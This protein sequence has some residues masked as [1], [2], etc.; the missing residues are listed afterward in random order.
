MKTIIL[1]ASAHPE[2]NTAEAVRALAR[3]IDAEVVDLLDYRILPFN[4]RQ[5]YPPEDDFMRLINGML[6]YDHLVFA[7]PVYWY[8]MSGPLKIYFDRISDLLKSHK[9]TGRKL[10]G[11]RMSVLSCANDAE[12]NDG[13]YEAF[14]LS[15]DYLGME[16]GFERHAWIAAGEVHFRQ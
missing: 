12:V 11:K 16:Y 9:S 5:E 15:A 8:S 2:G 1:Q 13:F 7:S 10:R 3:E 14:R 4:Y 6:Q